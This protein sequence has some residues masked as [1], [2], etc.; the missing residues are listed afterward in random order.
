MLATP[1]FSSR[2]SRWRVRVRGDPGR[3]AS[4]QASAIGRG[5]RPCGPRSLEQ[6]D[7]R[8]VGLPDVGGEARDVVTD[9]GLVELVLSPMLP[10]RKPLPSGL[11]GTKP[12]A[13]SA[14]VDSTPVSGLSG[15]RHHSEY[16][17]CRRSPV[18]RRGAADVLR[19]RL[20]HPECLTLPPS[21]SSFTVPAMSSTG[22][23]GVDAVLV[24]QV[25]GLHPSRRKSSRRPL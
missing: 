20:R 16:S 9:V 24:E 12:M 21:M 14:S 11:Y 8:A 22:T 4:N 2:R 1:R 23:F 7:H 18:A 13:S 19:R 17:L 10:V 3:C 6:V 15:S 25:D 5:S